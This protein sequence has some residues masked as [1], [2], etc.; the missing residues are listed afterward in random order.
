[1]RIRHNLGAILIALF[2]I[3]FLFS[4]NTKEPLDITITSISVDSS[5]FAE[6]L[7]ITTFNISAFE[8]KII[9]SD[10]SQQMIPLT[11][12][13]IAP[14]DL[15]KLSYIGTHQITITYQGFSV[16]VTLVLKNQAVDELLL[17]YYGFATAHL[18]YIGSYNE[19]VNSLIQGRPISI[20]FAHQN[21]QN[22]VIITFSNQETLNLGQMSLNTF[23]TVSFYG[24]NGELIAS[25]IVP[26]N[27]SAI[28]PTPPVI[29]DYQFVGW[30]KVFQNVTSSLEVYAIYQFSGVSLEYDDAD[31]LLLSIE[32]LENAQFS[33]NLDAIFAQK[34]SRQSQRSQLL[35]S[36]MF[37]ST[38]RDQ[39]NP[40][41]IDNYIPHNYWRDMYYHKGLYEEP[42]IIDGY[43]V[44]TSTLTA[45][46]D[47]ALNNLYNVT[48]QVTQSAKERADWAV[49]HI[50]VIDTWVTSDTYKYLL[51][52]NESL[53]RVELYTIWTSSVL[54]ITSYEKIYVYYNEK[55]EE[56]IESWI[57]QIYST[58]SYPG[59]MVYHNSVGA[60]DFNYYAIWLD[61]N[62]EPKDHPHFRGINRNDE[63]YYEYYDNHYHMVS[64]TF[65]WYTVSPNINMENGIFNY[66]EKPYIQVYSPD[67]SSNVISISSGGP[68]HYA[69][70]LYLPSMNGVEGILIKEGAMTT[71]NQDSYHSQQIILEAGLPLMPNWWMISPEAQNDPDYPVGFKTSKGTFMNNI[72]HTEETINFRNI[73][74][75]VSREGIRQYDHLHNYY[76]YLDLHVYVDTFDELTQQLTLYLQET[77]LSYK[78]GNTD[79]LFKELKDILNHYETIG[80]HVSI[81]NDTLPG[82]K[83]TYQDLE[84]VIETH[85]FLASYLR[86]R[87]DLM[88]M[89]ETLSEIPM[90]QMPSKY[91]LSRIALLS[92]SNLLTGTVSIEDGK[93]NT[94]NL[95]ATLRKSP[96][97]QKDQDY[98]MIYGLMIGG[99]WIEIGR[100][101]PKTYQVEDLMLQG[102][103]KLS[104]PQNL[105]PGNYT[106]VVFFAKVT[107]SGV[108]RISSF[109]PWLFES[110]DRFEYI[111][112]NDETELAT[113]SVIQNVDGYLDIDVR[114]TDI[115]PPKL[116]ILDSIV[117]KGIMS[118][119]TFELP[120]DAKVSDLL[121]MM[122]IN[123]NKDGLILADISMI[124]HHGLAVE[125][126]DAL[127]STGW[128]ITITDQADQTTELTIDEILFG[129]L[130]TFKIED[131]I[132]Y[133]TVVLPNETVQLPAE[134]VL[135]GHTFLN[136]DI[137]NLEI[138]EHKMIQALFQVNTY[139]ITWVYQDNIIR[140]DENIPYGAP[141]VRFEMDD[142]IGYRFVWDLSKTEMP[143]HDLIVSG[144]YVQNQYYMYF[145]IDG[146]F[147]S[148]YSYYYGDTVTYPVPVAPEGF[149]FSGWNV[150]FETMPANHITVEGFFVPITTS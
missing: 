77:G 95:L 68:G 141:I 129:Y 61:E 72:N 9:Y 114:L 64:G 79:D 33:I 96:L 63:G 140:I 80:R 147:Y 15:S 117:F 12:E 58:T 76:V 32:R 113:K 16:P 103:Q 111:E 48:E 67:A 42:A 40:Y 28:A 43:H 104:I 145:T 23:Y 34:S 83:N 119:T 127:T 144:D 56:V 4:C 38:Q 133:Q 85:K 31:R 131:F 13:M 50:T 74:L 5:Q 39:S 66:S 92:T 25:I 73:Y 49:D 150:N 93:I 45:F 10:G 18:G 1:M 20:I 69:V 136:W 87:F 132:Y 97:L 62:Y 27:G 138:T 59:V 37:K 53:D 24:F 146:I 128:K 57:E 52:Y 78:Y 121:M 70:S 106:F 112:K 105:S 124:T 120:L 125:M 14:L 2:L 126:N 137:E 110:F 75:F 8:I 94:E 65:G 19:W 123:D 109:E 149:E 101:T 86:I 41:D 29:Q 142:V 98:T 22:E 143:D 88:E 102:T 35:S 26:K 51:H 91:D 108:L 81:I 3:V 60:R 115:Y 36:I 148:V 139:Q 54:S 55:G 100:E 82:P 99:K 130:V 21:N 47:H 71:V 44:I 118:Q 6:P 17:S 7:E 135:K 84:T 89:V 46:N 30:N 134:P 116:T 11:S 122:K 90:E 107:T